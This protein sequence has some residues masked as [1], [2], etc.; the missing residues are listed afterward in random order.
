MSTYP[1]ED[2]SPELKVK[3]SEAWYVFGFLDV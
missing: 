3:A 1:L 2:D